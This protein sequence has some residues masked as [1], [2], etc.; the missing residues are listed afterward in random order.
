M[1][2]SEQWL[3]EWVD[4]S[5]T[6]EE[7]TETLTRAGLE[8]DGIEPAAPAFRGVVVGA[9]RDCRPHPEAERLQVCRVDAG[10]ETFDVVCG[11]PNARPG[12][13][14]PLARA[15]AELPDGTV[16]EA[17]TVRGAASQGMLCSAAELGL[18]DEAEG[19]LELPPGL[20]HGAD[21]YTALG[22]DDTVLE[23]D[24]TPNRADCLG[25]IGVARDLAARTGA[26]MA[27]TEPATVPAERDETVAVELQAPSDCP[28]Y[29]ARVIRGVDPTAPTPLWMRERLRRA[30]IRSVS[31]LV[32]ITNYVLLERGQPLHAFDLARL[33]P[34]I[35]V[36]HA[37]A[38]ESLTLIGGDAIELEAGTLVIADRNG[39]VAF[40]GVMGGE[41]TAVGD[42]TTDILLEAA[43][44]APAAIAGRARRHG[45][46]TDSSHRF[47]RGVDFEAPVPASER[48]TQLILEICGGSAGPVTE[49]SEPAHLPRRDPLELRT[50]RLAS[51]LGW[52]PEAEAVSALLYRLGLQPERTDEGWRVTPPSWRFD[53][54]REVD[55]I[56]EVARLL[57]YDAVPERPLEAPL[58]V[59]P[60]PE[61]RL[62]TDE[63]RETLVERGYHEAINYAFVDPALQHRLDP[64]AA[65]LH[66]A[67]PLSA[68]MAVMRSSLWPGLLMS[69]QRN[70]H[71]QHE[72]VRLFECGTTF[73]GTL[74]DL[75]QDPVIAGVCAGPLEPEHW[76]A[77]RRGADLFDVKADVEA[78]LARTGAPGT[79]RFE[80]AEHPALHPGQCARILR[81]G[82]HAG[83]LGRLHPQHAEA[84]EL[85]GEPVLFE[86]TEAS[87][88]EAALP[89]FRPLSRYP[90]I[91]RDLALVVDEQV[92][93]ADLVE[94]AAEAAGETLVATR[95]FDVYR[96]K[97]VPEG[98]KS[99]AMGLILQDYSRTLTDEDTE[100]IL[101][102]V[103]ARLQGQFGASL[104]GE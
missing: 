56:E 22:L 37:H 43:H 36:R 62:A 50:Q 99:I 46:H 63:L 30:G 102:S 25:M 74:D 29:T 87:L 55:L 88:A 52:A 61:Q 15:G 82:A 9:V 27:A 47:E 28:R 79:F 66:L 8:V 69:V 31:A 21:L 70:Q 81:D 26:A 51:L 68:E 45:L 24:L 54:E 60:A 84:L 80:P 96:G 33:A 18:S 48:A 86:L 34:P 14:A 44:F 103:V 32:D 39:P 6:T 10:D 58:H 94:A 76:D 93:A 57:G 19:L 49:Q 16:V 17:T 2:V 1:R 11:A 83:W 7:L 4:P 23:I 92:A 72:R 78:L 65:E 5:L 20:S 53:I 90:A 89:S 73:R 75:A 42:G 35:T 71:R 59:A 95:I 91:R 101:S 85:H 12:L 77:Q 40:A 64:E 41:P 97:G 100:G 104:R 67:N 13:L 98:S 3:R 38:G